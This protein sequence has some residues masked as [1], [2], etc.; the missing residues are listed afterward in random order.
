LI[1]GAAC[2]RMFCTPLARLSN[3]LLVARWVDLD[4]VVARIG[5]LLGQVIGWLLGDVDIRH[6][7]SL[8][9][10]LEEQFPA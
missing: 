7:F 9:F 6:D 3:A 8:G 5:C 10:G 4:G 1:A 2:W